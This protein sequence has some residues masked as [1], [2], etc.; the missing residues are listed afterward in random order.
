MIKNLII[1]TGRLKLYSIALAS[2]VIVFGC[3]TTDPTTGGFFGGV[4]GLASGNYERGVDNRRNILE[5]SQDRNLALAR[6][7][8]RLKQ[9]NAGITSDIRKA[10]VQMASLSK[11]LE[12]LDKIMKAARVRPNSNQ[13]EFDRM[14]AELNDIENELEAQQLRLDEKKK[15]AEIQQ[16]K[17]RKNQLEA[18]LLATIE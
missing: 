6:E 13:A 4:G 9:Q 5:N 16:L 7:S 17:K 10:Q 18:A 14:E 11:E 15:L 3:Q 1:I 8:K 12:T 2:L